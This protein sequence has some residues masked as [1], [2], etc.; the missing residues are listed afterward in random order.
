[1]PATVTELQ[2]VGLFASL[3]GEVLSRLA[4]H[5]ERIEIPSGGGFGSTDAA[6]DVLLTGLARGGDGLLRPGDVA[7]ETAT[8]ITA[9]V[10]ARC[11][12]VTLEEILRP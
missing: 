9:C 4:E 12:R 8:A 6:T 10:V 5:A 3:S 11:D 7:A 2:R 1:V